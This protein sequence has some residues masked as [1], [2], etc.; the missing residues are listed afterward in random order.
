M[1]WV[2]GWVV[3]IIGEILG[4]KMCSVKD[5]ST[6]SRQGII[7]LIDEFAMWN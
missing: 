2:D 6:G 4:E 5:M 1:L 3:C 7:F